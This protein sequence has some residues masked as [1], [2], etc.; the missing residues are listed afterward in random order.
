MLHEEWMLKVQIT[1]GRIAE[2]IS[3][4]ESREAREGIAI[5][6]ELARFWHEWTLADTGRGAMLVLERA[7]AAGLVL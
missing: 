5:L 2:K 3:E 1:L 7:E 4:D 6:A